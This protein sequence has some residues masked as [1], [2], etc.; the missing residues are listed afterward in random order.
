MF[1]TIS[2]EYLPKQT[3]GT[4]NEKAVISVLTIDNNE[5]VSIMRENYLPDMENTTLASSIASISPSFD[6]SHNNLPTTPHQVGKSIAEV[7]SP[8]R[9]NLTNFRD[10]DAHDNGYDSDGKIGPSY[11][12]FEEEGEKC[13]N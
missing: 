4:L 6:T 7:P 3:E 12:A 8:A 1:I 13:Y 5:H 10:D 2:N 9:R 11:N